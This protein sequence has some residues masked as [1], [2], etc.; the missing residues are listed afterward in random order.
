MKKGRGGGSKDVKEK[1]DSEDRGATKGR[2][3][4]DERKERRKESDERKEG[5]KEGR[6]YKRKE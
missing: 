1:K 2:K 3:E 5:R 4:S 6:K